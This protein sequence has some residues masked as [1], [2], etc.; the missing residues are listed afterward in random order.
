MIDIATLTGASAA[1]TGSHGVAMAGNNQE[2][3]ELLKQSGE[4][5]Y[6]RLLQM[7]LWKEF[8]DMLK[9]DIAELKNI[10]GPVGGVSTAA[11]F[12]EHFTDYPWIHLDIAGA[13]FIKD[14]SGYKQSGATGVTVR[15]LY[16]F[17]KNKC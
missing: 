17:I 13:S 7:P 10:G 5:V 8:A 6:E 12:L 3:I 16:D 1:V 2:Q 9:S 4:T 11:K 14:K 15:L